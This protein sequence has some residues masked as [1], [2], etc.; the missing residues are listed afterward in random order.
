[1]FFA[2]GC[3]Q[4][5]IDAT[6]LALYVKSGV[7]VSLANLLSRASAAAVGY[8]LNGRL[9]FNK[10]HEEL[11][12]T[13]IVR[14][15]LMWAGMT[16]LSSIL[17]GLAGTLATNSMARLEWLVACKVLIEGTLFLL[18]FMLSKRWVFR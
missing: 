11:K 2:I 16:A 13:M 15:W 5:A 10:R 8:Y 1:M 12:G 9:S 6:L 14:F 17:V 3:L 4:L 18:S 7:A